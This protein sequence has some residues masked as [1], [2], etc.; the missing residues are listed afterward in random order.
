MTVKCKMGIFLYGGSGKYHENNE[1]LHKM[2]NGHF[3]NCKMEK[4]CFQ[5][6]KTGK[7]SP[8]APLL[9]G[10]VCLFVYLLVFSC[11]NCKVPV[12]RRQGE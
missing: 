1:I 4:T 10:S 12:V 5:K 6:C 2:E 3:E 9:V 7:L 11:L 8:I